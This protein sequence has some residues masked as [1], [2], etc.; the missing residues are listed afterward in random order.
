MNDHFYKRI[1]GQGRMWDRTTNSYI[2]KKQS[3]PVILDQF[4]KILFQG[5]IAVDHVFCRSQ[6]VSYDYFPHLF[7]CPANYSTD[8][9]GRNRM[10]TI[11]VGEF[12][13][14]IKN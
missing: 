5:F 2:T 7:Y 9:Q 8:I 14:F 10:N 12:Q 6:I 13:Q 1:A 4:I 3:I 11:N